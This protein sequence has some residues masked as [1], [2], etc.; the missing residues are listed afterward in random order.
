M[1]MTKTILITGASS[2]IGKATAKLFQ[3]RSWNAV[4][5]MRNPDRENKLNKLDNILVTRLDVTDAESIKAAVAAG[6]ERFGRIDA[7]V[8]NAG[9]GAFGPPKPRQST[10]SAVSSTRTSSACW[11]PPR[12]S[13]QCFVR[14]AKASS[15]TS[16]RSAAR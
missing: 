12:P 5:A 9:Y 14:T 13:C 15:S 4:A 7:F 10:R 16:H 1:T 2:G 3:Q 6:I 8:N 11:R